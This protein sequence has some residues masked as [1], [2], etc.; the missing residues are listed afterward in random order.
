[1]NDQKL[2]DTG[3]GNLQTHY[4]YSTTDD[5]WFTDSQSIYLNYTL[6]HLALFARAYR[7]ASNVDIYPALQP[8][9]DMSIGLRKPDGT[10]PNVSNG[11]N[12]PVAMHLFTRSPDQDKAAVMLWNLKQ[13][14]VDG[15]ADTNLE[16]NDY[17]HATSFALT[18]F[19]VN[20]RPPAQSPTFLTRGQS[21]VSVFRNNWQP[22]SNYLFLS[23]GIDS[24]ALLGFPAFHS[25]NDTGEILV[26]ADGHYMLVAA[27]YNRPDLSNAPAK[28]APQDPTNHNVILVDGGLGATNEG[29]KMRPDRFTH[30][31]RL[32]ATERGDFRGASD[33]A[34]L[35]MKYGG[36]DVSRSVA[37]ANEDY[38]VVADRMQ[39]DQSHAYGFNLIGRGAM[40]TLTQSPKMIEVQWVHGGAQVI[41]HLTSTQTLTLATGSTF[42]HDT[43]NKYEPT[44]R[45]TA[46]AQAEAA[47]FLSVI[48]TGAAG[49]PAQLSVVDL[50]A[51]GYSAI[52]V[53]SASGAFN[54]WILS[55]APTG[56]I[57]VHGAFDTDAEYCYVRLIDGEVESSMLARG[58][59][60]T[61][62][63]KLLFRADHPLTISLWFADTGLYGTISADDFTPG[64]TFEIN[65]PIGSATV[66]GQAL[67]F[68]SKDGVTRI[69][70]SAP[71]DLRIDYVTSEKAS[72]QLLWSL[73][74]ATIG[75]A[76][77]G[78]VI[79]GVQILNR[80]D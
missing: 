32:D 38:F 2:L 41:E 5:G 6:R 71:G 1:M 80:R 44:Q 56:V 31:D 55:Q 37:F 19:N 53:N 28:F 57:S 29:R 77:A 74:A 18:N 23:P 70:L 48:E 27:G 7:Q 72:P 52:Q 36:A 64:T 69:V 39:S 20:A 16:N 62:S 75:V 8:L 15:F 42:M 11:V 9:L 30:T 45:M 49:S 26:S 40:T 33:F 76:V 10:I 51:P 60:L 50:S 43:F 46:T 3:L 73:G 4:S 67:D 63:G 13:L 54:D 68:R 25:Q 61:R 17:S 78:A 35:R 21:A 58:T 59:Q 24:A 66:N 47:S 14:P 22:E 34:T 65:R 12:W 79:L